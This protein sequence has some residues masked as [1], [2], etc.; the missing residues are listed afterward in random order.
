[1]ATHNRCSWRTLS[2]PYVAIAMVGIVVSWRVSWIVVIIFIFHKFSMCI[3]IS[4]IVLDI[5]KLDWCSWY[6]LNVNVLLFTIKIAWGW[7]LGINRRWNYLV[8]G[9]QL[10]V[11]EHVLCLHVLHDKITAKHEIINQ[12]WHSL[13]IITIKKWH[14]SSDSRPSLP[15]LWI[16]CNGDDNLILRKSHKSNNLNLTFYFIFS[17]DIFVRTCDIL[18]VWYTL[19]KQS[20][21]LDNLLKKTT[22]FSPSCRVQCVFFVLPLPYDYMMHTLF[23][24]L[25]FDHKFDARRGL[26]RKL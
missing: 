12:K 4:L 9:K 6:F 24:K 22:E 3:P 13:P 15:Q 8:L 11:K 26:P 7:M 16:F 19:F 23:G 21:N 10:K 5:K 25:K 18:F 20:I 2:C 17:T 1:M 14:V